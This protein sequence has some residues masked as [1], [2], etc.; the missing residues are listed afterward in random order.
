MNEA[1]QDSMANLITRTGMKQGIFHKKIIIPLA[2]PAC[3]G[4]ASH[5]SVFIL[6]VII[7]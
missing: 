4:L 5:K 7:F 1:M 2:T 6:T 3:F